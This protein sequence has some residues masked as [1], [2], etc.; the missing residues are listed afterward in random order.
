MTAVEAYRYITVQPWAASQDNLLVRRD[1]G[2]SEAVSE[3]LGE[4]TRRQ[5]TCDTLNFLV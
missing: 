4:L 5:I 3:K 2:K 1:L